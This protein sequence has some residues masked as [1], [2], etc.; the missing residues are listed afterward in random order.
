MR[1]V[2]LALVFAAVVSIATGTAAAA[3]YA[4]KSLDRYFR[5]KYQEE[6]NAAR[7]VVSGYGYNMGV[8]RMSPDDPT[9]RPG[10]GGMP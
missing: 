7:S 9:L 2:C 5:I 10:P 4:Q 1:G 3:N 6:A 8:P